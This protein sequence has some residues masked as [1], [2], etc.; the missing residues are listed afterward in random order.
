MTSFLSTS[1]ASRTVKKTMTK[2][3]AA[4]ALA[5]MLVAACSPAPTPI[6]QSASDP[7]N[8]KAAEGA[9]APAFV[10]ATATAKS[11]PAHD[12]GA[13]GATDTPKSESGATYVC[14]MHPE[15]TSSAPGTCPKCNMHLVI[16]K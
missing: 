1:R 10:A 13:H 12:H 6:A 2:N 16:K 9:P 11:A 15:V 4:L 5:G 14:P 3:T 8:P 7:S